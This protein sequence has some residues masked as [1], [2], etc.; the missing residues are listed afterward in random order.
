MEQETPRWARRSVIIG[1]LSGIFVL[2][3]LVCI[4]ISFGVFDPPDVTPMPF[5]SEAWKRADPIGNDRTVRSQMIDDLIG[6]RI[7]D[8]LSLAEVDKLLGSPISDPERLGFDVFRWHCYYRIGLERQGSW[9]FDT[10]Y[11]AIQFDDQGRVAK[12]GRVLY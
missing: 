2:G 1:T 8:G 9:S 11:L 5:E 10:E 3:T 4:V 6:R 12:Y 7:L